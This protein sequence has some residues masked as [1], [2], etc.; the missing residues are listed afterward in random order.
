[1]AL[2]FWFFFFQFFS[3]NPTKPEIKRMFMTVNKYQRNQLSMKKPKLIYVNWTFKMENTWALTYTEIDL[4]FMREPLFQAISSYQQN[5]YCIW[6]SEVPIFLL[7]KEKISWRMLFLLRAFEENDE[8]LIGI[9]LS[10]FHL[11][12][13]PDKQLRN[14]ST[15]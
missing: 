3:L 8:R 7:G 11:E 6:H 4:S 1:M 9:L 10:V 2:L 5:I 12:A 14:T 15:N 13:V